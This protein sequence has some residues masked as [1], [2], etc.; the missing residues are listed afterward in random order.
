MTSRILLIS[1]LSLNLVLAAASFHITKHAL[2]TCAIAYPRPQP[3][4]PVNPINSVNTFNSIDLD[5]Q[6][7]AETNWFH[8][9][10]LESPDFEQYVA[11]L[12]AVGCPEQTIRDLILPEIQKRYAATKAAV[13]LSGG[14]WCCGPTRT[15][16]ERARKARRDALDAEKRALVERLFG[17]IYSGEASHSADNLTERAIMLF[18]LGPLPEG[19]PEQVEAAIELADTSTSAIESQVNGILLPEDEAQIGRVREQNRAQLQQL[20]SPEQYEEF[21]ARW[22][23]IN[24]VDHGF[25]DFQMTAAE[26]RSVACLYNRAYGAFDG[27]PFGGFFAASPEKTQAQK[28]EFEQQL[29]M[30]L[31]EARFAEYQRQTNPDPQ[32]STKPAP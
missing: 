20:L 7:S 3:I 29:K 1:S 21:T 32:N 17:I 6:S 9:R 4:T 18:V 31:G 26:C 14:F 13:P 15:D 25:G 5:D 28:A 30:L 12:R 19:V 24:L 16:A 23:A 8:W 11:N 27:K 22:A 2:K 10:L